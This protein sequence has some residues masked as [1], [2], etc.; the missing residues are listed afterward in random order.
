MAL[1]AQRKAKTFFLH[2]ARANG[3]TVGKYILE[4][5]K[6]RTPAK[7]EKKPRTPKNQ[8]N[9]VDNDGKNNS[10]DAS[11]AEKI[12]E[13][14]LDKFPSFDPSW[15]SEVQQKWFDGIAKLQE[16]LKKVEGPDS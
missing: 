13:K 3:I 6:T 11:L 16:S 4:K 14:I 9:G 5:S 7:R 10:D 8:N 12:A 1:E 15:D 2:A